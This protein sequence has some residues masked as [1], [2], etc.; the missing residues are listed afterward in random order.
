MAETKEKRCAG[1]KTNKVVSDFYKNKTNEDGC[2]I[3]CKECT[4]LNAKKYY[5]KKLI[6]EANKVSVLRDRTQKPEKIEKKPNDS[7]I[8]RALKLAMIEKHI[9]T[10]IN[11]LKEYKEDCELFG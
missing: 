5:Q 7:G 1:C 6:K 4:K 8:E 11:L 3:Y 9:M 10:S 2:S